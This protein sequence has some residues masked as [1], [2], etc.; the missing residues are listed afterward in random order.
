MDMV[1]RSLCQPILVDPKPQF[2][3]WWRV[4]LKKKKEDDAGPNH[5][6]CKNPWHLYIAP[7]NMNP[8][9]FK[10]LQWP[11]IPSALTPLPLSYATQ[12]FSLLE[13][14]CGIAQG[15]GIQILCC[16]PLLPSNTN[17]VSLSSWRWCCGRWRYLR[18][19]LWES[20]FSWR[21]C[22]FL[23]KGYVSF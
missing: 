8:T 20:S 19:A 12:A 16:C 5:L 7:P 17:V 18:L 6:S 1:S 11:K 10:K 9:P 3:V 21:L 23:V 15:S 13:Y 22:Q 4:G 14:E 2:L